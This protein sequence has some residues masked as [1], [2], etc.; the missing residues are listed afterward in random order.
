MQACL[1]K[2]IEREGE[3]DSE[4]VGVGWRWFAKGRTL[5]LRGRVWRV[6]GSQSERVLTLA[7]HSTLPPP[8]HRGALYNSI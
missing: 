3:R 2:L 7:T 8:T 1:F 4:G 5:I 6:R